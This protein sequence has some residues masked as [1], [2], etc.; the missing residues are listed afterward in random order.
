MNRKKIAFIYYPRSANLVRL[1]TMPF[2]INSVVALAKTGWIIDLY[3]WEDPSPNYT[4]LFPENVTIKYFTEP[5]RT[6]FNL[7]LWYLQLQLPFKWRKKYCCVFGVSQIGHYIA[8]TIAKHNSA[9]FIYF[10]D[11]F[12]SYL[13]SN[14]ENNKLT[15]LEKQIVRKTS[16][17]IVPD[18]QRFI[19]LC[20]ELGISDLTPHAELPNITLNQ[21]SI[22]YI[23]WHKRLGI[24]SDSI[25]FLNAGSLA[26]WA[27]IPELLSSIP[28]WPAKV[29]LVLH[30]RSSEKVEAYRKQLS[31]LEIQGKI[32]WSLEPMEE[33]VLNSLVRYCAGNFALYRNSGPNIEYV[34][35]SSGK[36]LRSLASGSPVIAS[37]LPSLSFVSENKLGILVSHP[38]EIP[39]AIETIIQNREL[40]RTNCLQFCTNNL[41]F[42]NSW[43]KFCLKFKQ[44]SDIDLLKPDK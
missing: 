3:L 44:V 16:M 14:W 23:D 22:D 32:F 19:P 39:K 15:K 20:E 31:H 27:Q 1:D 28:Y 37:K 9:P 11:E 29:V 34:G 38:A 43:E 26:D 2:A 42:E 17:I 41:S 40:Y 21:T 33:S 25:P 7:L 36:L 10:N 13:G 6:P 5:R 8:H 4:T 35:L 30:S 18:S 24:P 12:P